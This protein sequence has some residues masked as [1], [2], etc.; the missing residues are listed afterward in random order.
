MVTPSY[1]K[2]YKTKKPQDTKENG[3]AILTVFVDETTT[4]ICKE[5]NANS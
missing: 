3:N 2:T 5:E 1:S 4:F